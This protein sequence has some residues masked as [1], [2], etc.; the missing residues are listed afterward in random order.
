[1]V[2]EME[3]DS[4]GEKASHFKIKHISKQKVGVYSSFPFPPFPSHPGFPAAGEAVDTPLSCTAIPGDADHG[5][6]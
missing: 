6:S 4:E 1:M 3:G 2:M 5:Q